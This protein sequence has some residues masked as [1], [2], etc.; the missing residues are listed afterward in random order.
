VAT[1]ASVTSGTVGSE[2]VATVT[3]ALDD[4]AVVVGE[5]V[6]RLTPALP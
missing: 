1:G 6:T 5:A 3:K 4:T 2:P